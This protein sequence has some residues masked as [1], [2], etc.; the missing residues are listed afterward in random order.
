MLFDWLN[1]PD[2]SRNNVGR[3]YEIDG[4]LDPERL[5]RAVTA[6]V[7]R[8][9]ILRTSMVEPRRVVTAADAVA[10]DVAPSCSISERFGLRPTN[11]S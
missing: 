6:L 7:E 3:A 9:E 2:S 11:T 10:F 5:E 1:D 4:S 8:H